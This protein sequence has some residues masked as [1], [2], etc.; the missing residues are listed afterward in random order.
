MKKRNVKLTRAELKWALDE[1]DYWDSHSL[2]D[3]WEQ[4]R[5]VEMDID[6]EQECYLVALDPELARRLARYSNGKGISAQTLLNLWIQERLS[7]SAEPVS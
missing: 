7:K 5:P 2:A 4:T 3:T 1:G 6:L